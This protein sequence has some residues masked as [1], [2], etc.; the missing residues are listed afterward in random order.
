MFKE[1]KCKQCNIVFQADSREL[2]RGN[3][4]FCSLS[5]AATNR[6]LNCKKYTYSCIL[7]NSN[8]TSISTKAKFCSKSCKYKNYRLQMKSKSSVNRAFMVFMISEP[9]EICK[10]N[11]TSCDVHHI[12]PISEGGKNEVTNLITL[13]PNCHRKVHKNLFSKDY[14]LKIVNFRTISSS[15]NSEESD[16]LAGN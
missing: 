8:F 3:A 11:D 14:L 2:N 16:A 1:T 6:N 15:S 4:L 10:W 12:L 7:C 9:C 5:C 13:C